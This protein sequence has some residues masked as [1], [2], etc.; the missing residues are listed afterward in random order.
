[1]I[2]RRLKVASFSLAIHR[3][4]GEVSFIERHTTAALRLS[5]MVVGREIVFRCAIGHR[6]H[7]ERSSAGH[8]DVT[9]EINQYIELMIFVRGGETII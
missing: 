5:Y 4:V 6:L 8:I 7:I 9:Q 2:E 1:M 3:D